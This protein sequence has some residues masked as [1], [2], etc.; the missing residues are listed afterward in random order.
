MGNPGA[1]PGPGADN[2]LAP[3]YIT[4]RKKGKK[5]KE[6]EPLID[7]FIPDISETIFGCCCAEVHANS[8]HSLLLPTRIHVN[9]LNS[10]F[11][12]ENDNDD[13]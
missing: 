13:D 8:G 2:N 10:F 11:W 5:K 1:N 3:C 4:E 7:L 6:D 9:C 12:N